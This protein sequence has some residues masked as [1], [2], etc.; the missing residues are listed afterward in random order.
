MTTSNHRSR[1]RLHLAL[2]PPLRHFLDTLPSTDRF[3]AVRHI[4]DA[5]PLPLP[6]STRLQTF[7]HLYK[8]IKNEQNDPS[9]PPLH[10]PLPIPKHP[11]M[12]TRSQTTNNTATNQPPPTTPPPTSRPLPPEHNEP[13]PPTTSR[14]SHYTRQ[15]APLAANADSTQSL[16]TPTPSQP[17]SQPHHTNPTASHTHHQRSSSITA[18]N[19]RRHSVPTDAHTPTFTSPENTLKHP[20]HHRH[21]TSKHT[22]SRVCVTTSYPN[23]TPPD[24]LT[25]STLDAILRHTP[26]RQSNTAPLP[27]HTHHPPLDYSSHHYSTPTHSPSKQSTTMAPTNP[28]QPDVTPATFD[29]IIH[30][31][32]TSTISA[33]ELRQFPTIPDHQL[34]ER[35]VRNLLDRLVTLYSQDSTRD[36]PCREATC[37]RKLSSSFNWRK[38]A[39]WLR[40]YLDKSI[41]LSYPR[42]E[43]WT[44]LYDFYHPYCFTP[45][46]EQLDLATALSRISDRL[47]PDT[48][49]IHPP[50]R[51]LRYRPPYTNPPNRPNHSYTL[52]NQYT[53]HPQYSSQPPL[54]HYIQ[55]PPSTYA[56]NPPPVR[57][58]FNNTTYPNPSQH[59]YNSHI[60][61]Q[62]HHPYNTPQQHFYTPRTHTSHSSRSPSNPWQNHQ[63]P[64]ARFQP[65]HNS[66][67]PSRPPRP[68]RHTYTH[69]LEPNANFTSYTPH[70]NTL[71]P[72]DS[73]PPP[74]FSYTSDYDDNPTHNPLSNDA[75]D[76]HQYDPYSYDYPYQPTDDTHS[77]SSVDSP[78]QLSPPDTPP[79]FP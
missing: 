3:H 69:S 58:P 59:S 23:I 34:N 53:S 65:Q 7:I 77:Y 8:L 48:T 31:T 68:F 10:L 14:P 13:N 27:K 30:E 51:P 56:S 2:T 24:D 12:Q 15:P 60:R 6:S 40:S 46:P 21:Q 63:S 39:T 52:R 54:N 75:T 18:T 22:Q 17:S 42:S 28:F 36:I 38:L 50:N 64:T 72:D 73:Y 9:A 47:A 44:R 26:R 11:K 1:T 76:S 45:R 29:D 62:P 74:H 41:H 37:I 16:T 71:S 25:P 55:P 78:P 32:Y 35:L 79:P 20:T 66:S 19:S 67:P 43:Y 33:A 70:A 4:N 61:P 57:P 5:T 49:P